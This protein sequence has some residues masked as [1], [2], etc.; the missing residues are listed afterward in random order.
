MKKVKERLTR[1]LTQLGWSATRLS[2]RISRSDVSGKPSAFSLCRITWGRRQGRPQQR[3]GNQSHKYATRETLETSLEMGECGS[4]GTLSHVRRFELWTC[5][6]AVCFHL[7][8]RHHAPAAPIHRTIHIP[9]RALPTRRET[10]Q[11]Q[12]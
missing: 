8:Q 1:R 7:F 3:N 5:A 2:M 4:I 11:H 12:P 10:Q 9:I 6:R